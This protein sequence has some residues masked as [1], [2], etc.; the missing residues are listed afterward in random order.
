MV[1]VSLTSYFDSSV[2]VRYVIGHEQSIQNLTPYSK[3][4]VTSA[5]TAIECLRVLDRWRI[6]KEINDERLISARSLCLKIL[7]GLRIIPVDDHVVSMASQTFPIAMKSLY[8]IHLA[9]ALHFQNQSGVKVL[10]LTH[11]IKLQMAATAFDMDVFS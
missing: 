2:L 7:S 10:L 9:S 5:I 11:D 1:T 6:T 4:A 8:A 3:G